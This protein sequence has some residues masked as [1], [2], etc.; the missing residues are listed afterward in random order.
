MS[1]IMERKK[2]YHC[3]GNKLPAR[4]KEGKNQKEIGIEIEIEIEI[5]IKRTKLRC[6][7]HIL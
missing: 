1:F 4:C 3:K 5:E 7:F 6:K 2:G